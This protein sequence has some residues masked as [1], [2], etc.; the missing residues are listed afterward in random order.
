MEQAE[1]PAAYAKQIAEILSLGRVDN[2]LYL[3]LMTKNKANVA[4][5]AE[6]RYGGSLCRPSLMPAALGLL[7]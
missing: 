4:V 7:L 1:V 2:R 5:I 3:A 6:M